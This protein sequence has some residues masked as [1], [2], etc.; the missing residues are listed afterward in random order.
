M[1]FGQFKASQLLAS[2]EH[3]PLVFLDSVL[4]D[5]LM[6]D[7]SLSLAGA[8]KVT[9]SLVLA[10]IRGS[11]NG[12]LRNWDKHACSATHIVTHIYLHKYRTRLLF[13]WVINHEMSLHL[14]PVHSVLRPLL[15]GKWVQTQHV[16]LEGAISSLDYCGSV[17]WSIEWYPVT[18]W[19]CFWRVSIED[20]NVFICHA[21]LLSKYQLYIS[22]PIKCQSV[23]LSLI[24]TCLDSH[25]PCH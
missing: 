6:I 9:I 18:S 12:R 7:D 8:V 2:T 1:C 11:W 21:Q 3:W 20:R 25:S 19:R 23:P 24:F 15:F 13:G 4:I 16:R 17:C 10:H 5:W 14:A 22:I